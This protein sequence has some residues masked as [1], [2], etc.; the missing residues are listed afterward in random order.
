[1]NTVRR[2]VQALAVACLLCLSMQAAYATDCS[3]W[4]DL[5]FTDPSDTKQAL[6]LRQK[7]IPK[8]TAN[9]TGMMKFVVNI[10]YFSGGDSCIVTFDSE[11]GQ[12]NIGGGLTLT[13]GKVFVKNQ[14]CDTLNC[15]FN[16]WSYS[17]SGVACG[18]LFPTHDSRYSNG[19]DGYKWNGSFGSIKAPPGN[20]NYMAYETYCAGRSDTFWVPFTI[21]GNYDGSLISLKPVPAVTGPFSNASWNSIGWYVI[22]AGEQSARFN[23]N[24][25]FWNNA[26]VAA[27]LTLKLPPANPICKKRVK[28]NAV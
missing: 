7:E 14:L 12:R 5:Y 11:G 17:H 3:H 22:A 20:S 28:R 4:V 27:A 9:L 6:D 24:V 16:T 21:T 10:A 1:M 15:F 18:E 23:P 13:W 26:S 25:S 8:G 2:F 19:K